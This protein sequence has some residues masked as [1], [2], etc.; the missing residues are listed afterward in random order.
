M[1]ETRIAR[2]P[3]AMVR[4]WIRAAIE[5]RDEVSATDLIPAAELRFLDDPEFW[6]G[7]AMYL[8]PA[9]VS[10]E[11]VSVLSQKRGVS[12]YGRFYMSDDKFEEA[13][14]SMRKRLSGWY[15]N[16]LDSTHKV[17]LRMRK[18]ELVYAINGRQTQVNGHVQAISFMEE[19]AEGLPDDD[20]TVEEFY[21][22]EALTNIY[23]RY[24]GEGGNT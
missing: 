8:L 6:N 19:L 9:L 17:M 16:S 5:G 3:G 23:N 22:D 2:S 11:L 4:E 14:A 24:Y 7:V 21:T 18:P 15:E 12:K 10:D 1:S 13:V 20:V